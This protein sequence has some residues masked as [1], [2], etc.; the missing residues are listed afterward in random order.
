[1]TEN[2][3]IQKPIESSPA[4]STISVEPVRDNAGRFTFL[5]NKK[6]LIFLVILLMAIIV[7]SYFLLKTTM[8]E[9]LVQNKVYRV[10]I[11][12]GL[13]LF[14]GIADSFKSEMTQLGFIE[15]KNITYYLQK[16]NYEPTKEQQIL[17]KFV[18]DKVDLILG[19]NTD[20]A[21]EAKDATKGTKIPVIFANA[22]TEGNNLIESIRAPGGNITGVRYPNTDV[23]IK[24]LE[25]LHEI[26]P[27]AKKMW[28]PYQKDYPSAPAEL[29]VVRSA[30][31]KLGITLI[32]FPAQNL[33]SLG[34]EL[35]RRSKTG[36]LGFDAVLFIPESLSTTKDAFA[37]IAN[38]TRAQKIPIC[39]SSV[40]TADY[41]TIF[42]VTIDSVEIGKLAAHLADKVFRG[43]P[44]GTIPVVSPETKLIV[45]YKVA[46]ELGITLNENLL[47]RA[48]KIIR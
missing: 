40:S 19:Y 47:N 10:G 25:I 14:I 20:V 8:K 27:Q 38:Y 6:I 15:G 29:V 11:L 28:L 21:L 37:T 12:S 17:K 42:A 9:K 2:E 41:G 18:D 5:K 4:A 39:G 45:N 13:D 44:T 7:G 36:D 35:E 43:I 22:F 3:I 1:M 23:A 31:V 46:T 48:D 30:A 26:V 33:A 34:A 24:R 16:T 32:E